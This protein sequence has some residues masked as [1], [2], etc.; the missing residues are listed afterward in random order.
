MPLTRVP[1][2][3]SADMLRFNLQ[4]LLNQRFRGIMILCAMGLGV[5]AVVVLTALGEGAR[6]YII[7]EFSSI[8]KDVLVILPGRNETTGGMPPLMGTAARDITLEEAA[9]LPQRVSAIKESVPV[10]IGSSLVEY[11]QRSREVITL[12]STHLF[13]GV[14][15]LT[16]AQGQ[17]LPAGDFR[18]ATGEALIGE[19]L[20]RALFDNQP[21]I[22][23]FVRIGDSRFRVAGVLAPAVGS[24]GIDFGDAVIIP[25]ASA[26]RLFNV[27]GLFR[28]LVFV[29]DGYPVDDVKKR[30]EK[31]MQ[32]F[33]QG[34]L[35]ITV[36]SPDSMRA[37][38]DGI[39]ATM[40]LAIGAIGA[41]SLLVAGVL[42]MNVML[43]SVSQR[44]REIGL[45]K[46]LGASAADI[47]RIFL[48]EAMLMTS[49][50]A[51]AGIVLGVIL[52]NIGCLVF[53]DIPFRTPSWAFIAATAVALVTG[54]VFSWLPARRASQLQPVQALQKP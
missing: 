23:A 24:M 42:I 11:Q 35:D 2:L 22:G 18:R 17:N 4:T 31:T 33:H 36:I 30:I 21:A 50:G 26:Q 53:P 14:N 6:G 32:D 20:K 38:F 19:N 48:G 34:E 25:V 39:L 45:L 51:I 28:V 27:T 9:M 47:L 3:R 43:I 5:A 16:L 12:G 13:A 52:V 29:R 46:A 41:I 1:L 8:G 49:A 15:H 10:I 40:T 54:L 7:N 44:T 37:T